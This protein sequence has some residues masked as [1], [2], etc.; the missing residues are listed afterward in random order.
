MGALAMIMRT[1][2]ATRSDRLDGM[3]KT[4]QGSC[5]CGAVRFE[6][7]IDLSGGTMRCNC[8]FCRKAR[9]WITFVKASDFRLLQ[10]AD[11]LTDYQHTPP[12]KPEPFLH[13]TFC[14][15]CG[16][17]AFTKGGVMPQFGGEFYAVNIMCLD[18][19][20]DDDLAK[21]PIHFADGR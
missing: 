20:S 15:H 6:A 8:G 2:V 13:F 12:G 14:R 18:G 5:H 1:S 21:V 17:R 19:V 9:F 3:K 16:F 4:Y 7:E 10:G 11:A